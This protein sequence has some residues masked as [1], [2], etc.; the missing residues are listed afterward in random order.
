M[1]ERA[2]LIIATGCSDCQIFRPISRPTAPALIALY[3]NCKASRSGIFFP[4]ATIIGTGQ[5]STTFSKLSQ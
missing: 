1:I 5:D 3:V 2:A 4:P